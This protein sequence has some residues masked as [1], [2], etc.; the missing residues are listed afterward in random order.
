VAQTITV[1]LDR[2]SAVTAFLYAAE[3]P[4]ACLILGHGAGAGQHSSFMVTFAGALAS[5]GL[6][7]VTFNFPYTEYGRKIPDRGP[8]LEACYR[9]VIGAVVREV[10]SARRFLAVG[11]KS[12]GGRIATQVA[13][14]DTGLPIGGLVLLG[15]PLHPPGKPDDRRDRH[16]PSIQRPVLFVQGS[17]DTFGTPEEL[18][19]V[20][21]SMSPPAQLHVVDG[22]DHS[23]KIRRAAEQKAVYQ[24]VQR[25]IVEWIDQI[26]GKA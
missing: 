25:A 5:L 10:P 14:S 12:M 3:K 15:Y 24:A 19:P 11:G 13:A 6:D 4:R 21:A 26:S 23:F 9:T 16:L 20:A 22:G 8:V 2:Q 1:Q 18:A 7:A 17:R